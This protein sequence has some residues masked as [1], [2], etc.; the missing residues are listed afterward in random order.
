MPFQPFEKGNPGRKP[1]SR[2]RI[3]AK[4]LQIV[5]D[6]SQEPALP[7]SAHTKLTASLEVMWKQRPIEYARLVAGLLPKT[8]DIADPTIADLNLEQTDAMLAQLRSRV[9]AP[10]VALNEVADG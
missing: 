1:G 2:N 8:V 3:S 4:L 10:V 5:F 6:H 9:L 7:G